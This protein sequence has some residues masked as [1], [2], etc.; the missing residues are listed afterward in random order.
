[1]AA[2]IDLNNFIKGTVDQCSPIT[3]THIVA[4]GIVLVTG[5]TGLGHGIGTCTAT[6]TITVAVGTNIGFVGDIAQ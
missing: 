5:I 6:I 1:M 3:A 2:F 4:V